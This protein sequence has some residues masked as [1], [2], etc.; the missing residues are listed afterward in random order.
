MPKEPSRR[1]PRWLAIPCIVALLVLSLWHGT[2]KLR[3]PWRWPAEIDAVAKATQPFLINSGYG[4][5]QEMTT[6]R[7]E[8]VIEGSSD[9]IEWREYEFRWKPGAL[10]R[11]PGLL[12]GHMPRLDW[13][14]WFAALGD[15]DQSDLWFLPFCD[16][17]LDGSASVRALLANDP[18]APGRPGRLRALRYRYEFTTAEQHAFT[19]DWWWRQPIDT[20]MPP[21]AR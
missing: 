18:F 12:L 20:Y 8:I 3:W 13:Q 10:D 17:L 9:G 11:R 21:I 14:M 19:S 2:Q 7:S 15:L 1:L 4:L 5:F 6:R 16:R